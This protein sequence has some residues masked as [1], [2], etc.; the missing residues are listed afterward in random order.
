MNLCR[1]TAACL[2]AAASHV[3]LADEA[4]A[5]LAK[6]AEAYRSN[7]QRQEH[8]NWN[9]HETRK[10]LDKAG[11]ALQTFPSVTSESII[12]TGGKRCNAILAWGD[13]KTPY[14]VDAD[15]DARCQAMDAIRPPFQVE[16]V[17]RSSKVLQS[18]SAGGIT[19]AIS[20]DK[21]KLRDPDFDVRCA[22]SIRATVRLEPATFFPVLL[23]GEVVESGCDLKSNPV[24]Q[25][26]AVQAGPASST[27]RKSAR[28]H[29]EYVLQK[30][31]FQNPA[32][33]FWICAR[34]EFDQ[35]WNS[36][37]HY[38]YYWGRQLA[39]RNASAGH[40]FI[41]EIKTTARE[42]G[43]ETQLRFDK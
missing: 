11:N 4:A 13:G 1:L 32:N 8:W 12:R 40:R 29:M 17:L 2:L 43:A 6:A 23:E 16:A 7:Q 20:P 18:P 27:F 35:P 37:A 19:L 28:F 39:V 30:D 21:S 5:M 31:R 10:L 3:A 15:P 41:K 22:A 38:L 34:Q 9:I 42:F 25:Y 26:T 36:D 24:T 33:S 14:M